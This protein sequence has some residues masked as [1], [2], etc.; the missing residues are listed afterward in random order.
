MK[1][2]DAA[3]S[4]PALA[5]DCVLPDLPSPMYIGALVRHTGASAKAIRLY[6]SLGL[7]GRVPRLGAYRVYDARHVRQV[8][9]IRQAQDLG[10]RLAEVKAALGRGGSVEPDWGA[11]ATQVAHQRTQVAQ[12]IARLQALQRNLEAIALE[13][14]QCGDGAE[15]AKSAA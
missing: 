7:L 12:E 11:V 1:A 2:R 5:D 13:L 6:E 10:L 15:G 3:R 9:L 4:A 8:R 14:A